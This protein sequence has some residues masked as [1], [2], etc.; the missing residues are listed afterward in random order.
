M[1][2]GIS[3]GLANE[4]QQQKFS[5]GFWAAAEGSF[6]PAG[7]GTNIDPKRVALA[8]FVG[9][10]AAELGGGKF[11]NGAV[12]AA[13][14]QMYNDNGH[15][16]PPPG[17]V[18]RTMLN[19]EVVYVGRDFVVDETIYGKDV[20][21]TRSCAAMDACVEREY[22]KLFPTLTLDILIPQKGGPHLPNQRQHYCN[23][24]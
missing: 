6:A 5:A 21:S 24:V 4:L 14:L 22:K 23:L 3:G 16:R 19:G 11:S 9:G 8:A 12:T 1:S 15:P 20:A 18:K 10:A 7:A 13:F 17:T 2:H